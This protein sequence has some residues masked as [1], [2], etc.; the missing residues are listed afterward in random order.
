MLDA[1]QTAS[2]C[3]KGHKLKPYSIEWLRLQGGMD[4]LFINILNA[5]PNSTT[6]IPN[7]DIDYVLTY[8]I[9]IVN[10]STLQQNNPCFSD[11]LGI[12]FDIDLEKFFSSSY[13]DISSISPRALT[14]GNVKS[15]TSYLKYISEQISTH[16]LEE[17]VSILV[18]KAQLDPMGFAEEDSNDLNQIDSHLTTII[19]NG[20]RLCS[21]RH[22]QRQSWSP[23]QREIGRT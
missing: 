19:L 8:G 7:R 13:A 14:S 4:D 6:V 3:F 20:E 5:R 12:V 17:K 15:V 10:I 22:N 21:N 2:E 9:D 11:H 18:E 1:N 16:K 23:T